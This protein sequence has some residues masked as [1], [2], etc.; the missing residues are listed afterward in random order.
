MKAKLRDHFFATHTVSYFETDAMG[1]VH[2]SNYLRFFEDARVA[3]M[4]SLGLDRF[5]FPHA[6]CHWAV[7]ESRVQHLATSTFGDVL[8]TYVQVRRQRLK[9]IFQYVTFSAEADQPL[10]LGETTLVPVNGAKKVMRLPEAVT[11]ALE[12]TTWTETWL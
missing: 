4:C 10:A 1:V 7:L 6:D 8:H 9:I 3:W 12:K 2:H 5:H 11:E